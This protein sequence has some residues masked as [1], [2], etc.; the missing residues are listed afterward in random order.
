MHKLL[1]GLFSTLALLGV[2]LPVCRAAS[3]Y[4]RSPCQGDEVQGELQDAAGYVCAPRCSGDAF[5]CP[6]DMP[7]GSS[8]QPQCMLQDVDRGQFCG[9]LCQVDSECP[10]GARCRQM[11]QVSLCLYPA[12]FSDWARSSSNTRRLTVGWPNKQG[13]GQSTASFQIAKT[14]AALQSLKS[15]FSID[16]G[17]SDMLT[18]KELLSS[19]S[20][21]GLSG[22]GTIPGSTAVTAAGA[23]PSRQGNAGML[24]GFKHDI[25]KFE[26][27]V[28]DGIPGIER[29]FHDITWNAEHIFDRNGAASATLRGLI[30]IAIVYVLAGSLFKYQT[31]AR[32]LDMLPHASFWLEYPNLV[33]DG[34]TYSKIL[35]DDML[36]V[37]R[38]GNQ[39]H[40]GVRSGGSGAFETL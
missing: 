33:A 27:Y 19:L 31:G 15:R 34:V 29:E 18:L 38:S 13:G 26:G 39:L 30:M 17:D 12:S 8:A 37:P 20:A 7:S 14:Y 3:H 2:Q 23:A 36:G 4:D 6:S 16:D 24:S 10:S 11:A 32:G 21:S 35:I 25:Q 1:A 9:L 40:G 22:V 5:T 28:G